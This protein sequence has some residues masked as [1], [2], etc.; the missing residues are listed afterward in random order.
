MVT[1]LAWTENGGDI[2]AI[3]VTLMTGKGNLTLTGQLGEIMQESAQA[4]MSYTRSQ[5]KKLGIKETVF[6]KTDVHIHVPEGSVPK[7]GPSAGITMATALISAFTGR[8][9]Y[10]QIAMTGE[11]TLRGRVLPVGGIKEKVLAAHRAGLKKVIIPA[12]NQKDL[13]ELHK[14]VLRELQ[15]IYVD[16][17]D[18]VLKMALAPAA[19]TGKT[20]TPKSKPKPKVARRIKQ[21]TDSANI[22]RISAR[23]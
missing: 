20:L 13:V 18:E 12:R 22:G 14:K 4:A 11:I 3:E 19:K 10:G 2:I 21:P 5:A 15:M 1:G 6:E 23:G 7:D 8:K 16:S 9:A 17:M